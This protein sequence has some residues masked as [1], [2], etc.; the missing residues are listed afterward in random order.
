MFKSELRSG[1][2]VQSRLRLS[3]S[4][5][6]PKVLPMVEKVGP[7]H[8][9]NPRIRRPPFCQP[10]TQQRDLRG[11]VARF[12]G[13]TPREQI[14]PDQVQNERPCL[15]NRLSP[16]GAIVNAGVLVAHPDIV[17]SGT[18]I[19]RYRHRGSPRRRRQLSHHDCV[20]RRSEHAALRNKRPTSP[21]D[22]GFS[23]PWRRKDPWLRVRP[24]SGLGI[25]LSALVSSCE[26]CLK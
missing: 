24:R 20:E 9:D 23:Y 21:G 2:S 17:G 13:A 16:E 6:P 18:K 22:E 10:S 15:R 12:H 25:R 8:P 11:V 26:R 19:A 4:W 3:D 1:C 7:P 14:T 5:P